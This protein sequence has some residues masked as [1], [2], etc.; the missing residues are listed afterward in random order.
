MRKTSSNGAGSALS[1]ARRR[2]A[3]LFAGSVAALIVV[4]VVSFCMGPSSVSLGD[5]AAFV[6]GAPWTRPSP[7]SS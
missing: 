6:T 7:I 2:A 3:R 4:A 1:H 5:I